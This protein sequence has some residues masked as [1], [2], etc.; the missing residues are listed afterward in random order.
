MG[1]QDSP[2]STRIP[3]PAGSAE[4][5]VP[6]GIPGLRAPGLEP[7]GQR[8]R[9]LLDHLVLERLAQGR[10]QRLGAE[11]AC[12]GSAAD[13]GRARGCAR[14]SRSG[15]RDAGPRSAARR[16][17]PRWWWCRRRR[18]GRS[19]P[20]AG[21]AARA[22]PSR[23]RARPPEAAAARAPPSPP[24]SARDSRPA[25][26]RAASGAWSWR[27]RCPSCCR[28]R[29]TPGGG[30]AARKASSFAGSAAPSVG[31]RHPITV[32]RSR[33]SAGSGA[34]SGSAASS[35]RSV[36]RW[37]NTSR[38]GAEPERGALARQASRA[39]ARCS[40]AAAATTPAGWPSAGGA[41]AAARRARART[42]GSIVG[43]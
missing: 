31:C 30:P 1:R 43:A 20:G 32:M 39:A 25:R 19:P 17:G 23:S 42:D 8:P 24:R 33:R 29:G 11:P 5:E 41:E 37:V 7:P 21:T 16:R 12:D 18:G 34:S 4:L 38:T 13:R 28:S 3:P 40:S 15:R 35:G 22:R 2:G 27:D 10:R 26:P 9:P 14:P 6:G 36:R